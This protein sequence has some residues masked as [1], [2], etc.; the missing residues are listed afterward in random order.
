M[1][2]AYFFTITNP[3]KYY[4]TLIANIILLVSFVSFS[5]IK[6]LLYKS[7]DCTSIFNCILFPNI[8]LAIFLIRL[9][10]VFTKRTLEFTNLHFAI[11]ACIGWL[12]MQNWLIAAIILLLGVMEYVVNKDANCVI[13]NKGIRINSF[14]AKK[15]LWKNIEHVL[16]KEGIFTIDQKNNKL[17]QIDV[18]EEKLNIHFSPVLIKIK[19]VC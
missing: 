2:D 1:R 11:I 7:G 19:L 18:S 13:N 4:Y 5:I 9:F 12:N 16:L 6:Y 17:F 15:Y 8:L 14:P 10:Y 3:K